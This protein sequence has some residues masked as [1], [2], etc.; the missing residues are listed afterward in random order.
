MLT[1]NSELMLFHQIKILIFKDTKHKTFALKVD[2]NWPKF[3]VFLMA[4][5]TY[6]L[7]GTKRL[8]FL[9]NWWCRN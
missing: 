4:E 9:F 5:D 8:L 6:W 1:L 7:L 2:R 3:I